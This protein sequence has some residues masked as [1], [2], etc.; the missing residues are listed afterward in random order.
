MN[1]VSFVLPAAFTGTFLLNDVLNAKRSFL[2]RQRV[3][4]AQSNLRAP[5]QL[6]NQVSNQEGLTQ[7]GKPIQ[8]GLLEAKA[9]KKVRE[10]V[11][12]LGNR[13]AC[14]SMSIAQ[15]EPQK[16]SPFNYPLNGF[17]GLGLG[18]FFIYSIVKRIK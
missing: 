14:L 4:E 15:L 8:Q 10:D 7:G 13:T 9:T 18:L 17:F 12:E 1:P 11:A 3:T 16:M 5:A 2:N 6:Q